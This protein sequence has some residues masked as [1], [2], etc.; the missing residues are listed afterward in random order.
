MQTSISLW[1]ADTRAAIRAE[2]VAENVTEQGCDLVFRTW[3]DTRFARLRL[4]W[5]AIGELVDPEEWELY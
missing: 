1:D 5:M 2:V 4:A 3:G